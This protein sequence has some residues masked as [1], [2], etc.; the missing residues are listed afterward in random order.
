M[1]KLIVEKLTKN[2]RSKFDLFV[3]CVTSDEMFTQENLVLI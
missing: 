2:V 1:S 3:I